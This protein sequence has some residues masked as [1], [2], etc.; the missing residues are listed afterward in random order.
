M[1]FPYLRA[2]KSSLFSAFCCLSL[3]LTALGADS[4][5]DPQAAADGAE[6]FWNLVIAIFVIAV[7]AASAALPIA[8][9][10]QWHGKWRISAIAPLAILLLWIAVIVVARLDSSDAHRLWPF[11]IFAWAMLNMIYM[12]AVMTVKRVLDKEDQKNSISD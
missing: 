12:V 3:P 10:R 5:L 8:A 1:Q 6:W 7:S 9:I 11:E 4:E 2:C